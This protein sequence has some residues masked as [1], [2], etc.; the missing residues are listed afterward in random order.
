[1]K[2]TKKRKKR[3]DYSGNESGDDHGVELYDVEPDSSDG[4][5]DGSG[6]DCDQE[7]LLLVSRSADI[8]PTKKR[9]KQFNSS[10]NESSVD[11]GVE[12]NDVEPNSSDSGDETDDGSSSDCGQK[13]FPS[14]SRLAD[15]KTA[16]K[17]RKQYN[18]SDNDSSGGSQEHS[19]DSSRDSNRKMR[20]A[21]K[22]WSQAELNLLKKFQK[23]PKAP[24]AK[25][26]RQLIEK[27][28]ILRGRTEAQIKTR[29]LY[30][31]KTGR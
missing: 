23:L 1:M 19:P 3:L 10:G 9:R 5:D 25:E 4:G 18:F 21:T 27:H 30:M 8:K 6:S 26:I 11:R 2:T 7:E 16:K 17:S 14:G 22:K 29:A 31:Q 28:P 20:T 13:E 12:L 24:R 15:I